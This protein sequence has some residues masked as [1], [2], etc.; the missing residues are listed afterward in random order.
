MTRG[1]RLDSSI[2]WN[3]KGEKVITMGE[4]NMDTSRIVLDA[5]AVGVPEPD[6][7]DVKAAPTTECS[8]PRLLVET[9]RRAGIDSPPEGC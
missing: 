6:P 4:G 7:N 1:K 3:N 2:R 8:N 5:D 9:S